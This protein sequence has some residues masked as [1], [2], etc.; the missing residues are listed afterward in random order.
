MD[1]I[2]TALPRVSLY[3]PNQISLR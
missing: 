1:A 3:P 2:S